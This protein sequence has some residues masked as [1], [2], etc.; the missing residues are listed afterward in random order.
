MPPDCIGCARPM[1]RAYLA[2]RTFLSQTG[3]R[4]P[5]RH[6]DWA[7]PSNGSPSLDQNGRFLALDIDTVP[8][9][10]VSVSN[11][12]GSSTASQR[13]GRV[14]AAPVSMAGVRAFTNSVPIDRALG[15]LP[16]TRQL[17]RAQRPM[18]SESQRRAPLS[19]PIRRE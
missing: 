8:A 11:G 17:Q 13:D 12:P 4:V 16:L 5:G 14:D 18:L 9:R 19:A 15:L 6:D 7:G 10:R 1:S 3:A 2:S